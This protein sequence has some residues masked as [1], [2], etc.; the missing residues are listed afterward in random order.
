MT[1]NG[2]H[3]LV[4]DGE[5]KGYRILVPAQGGRLG[6]SSNNDI[7]LTDPSLSRH[8]CR[9]FFKN[10]GTLWV[11]DLGSANETLVNGIPVQ[12]TR[13]RV[14][15]LITVGDTVIE[16]VSD[17]VTPRESTATGPE[18]KAD[19]TGTPVIDLGLSAES[20]ESPNTRR[21]LPGRRILL[22]IAGAAALLAL[23][24]WAPALLK[25]QTPS[26]AVQPTPEPVPEK[27][28]TLDVSYEKV[29]ATP[30]NVFRYKLDISPEGVLAIKIDDIENSR[31]VRR[32]TK[33]SD[34]L[35]QNLARFLRD[36]GFFDLNQDYEGYR[37]DVLDQWRVSLTLDT[38]THTAT[39][40][41]R[42]PPEQMKAV[43]ERLEQFGKR[44]L[45]LWAIQFSAEKLKKMAEEAMLQGKKLYAERSVHHGNLSAAIK[46]FREAEWYLETVE[47]KPDFYRDIVAGLS[48]CAS[49]LQER[50]N[51]LNFAAERA[52]KLRE[53][54]NAAENLRIIC[55]TIPD[56][57]DKRNKDARKKLL[58][59]EERIASEEQ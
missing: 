48:R 50:Y 58:L 20:R 4:R 30:Q 31:H 10:D 7:V 41:N 1:N 14:N 3:L 52:F 27:D 59:A 12:E 55:E 38:R 37:K 33:V 6:R 26:P 35:I 39:V 44:E 49:E 8:H 19:S 13:L 42:V 43:T 5:N 16:V 9:F 21:K 51:D 53:W 57:S 54:E 28:M 40:K 45:G 23:M 18:E 46:S 15:N 47:P 17:T 32:E 36:S 25:K 56:R 2:F 11:T 34:E 24:V 22:L 29:Q